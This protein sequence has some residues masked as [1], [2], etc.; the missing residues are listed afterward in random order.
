M[1]ATGLAV[2]LG[3]CGGGDGGGASVGRITTAPGSDVLVSQDRNPVIAGNSPVLAVNPAQPT[4][5]VVVDRIDRPDY[6]AGVHVTNNAGINWQ[7][8]GL[9]RPPR[10]PGKPSAP[11]PA[12]DRRAILYDAFA[13]ST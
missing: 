10:S 6:G 9:Q 11:P 5:M 7:D 12:S 8:I 13:T 3:A 1:G 2:I 4:N